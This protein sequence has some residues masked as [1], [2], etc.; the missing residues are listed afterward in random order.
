MILEIEPYM[1]MGPIRLG[2]TIE[3]VEAVI[4]TKHKCFTTHDDDPA[5]LAMVAVGDAV[6][7]HCKRPG[8]CVQV[9]ASVPF[10][11]TF[12]GQHLLGVPFVRILDWFQKIDPQIEI[13]QGL[14]SRKFGIQVTAPNFKE[15]PGMLSDTAGIFESGLNEWYDR[16]S[17]KTLLA[18]YKEAVDRLGLDHEK[19]RDL[20][21]DLSSQYEVMGQVDE[22]ARWEKIWLAKPS[23]KS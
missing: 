14:V 8:F 16:E 23:K 9:S 12:R 6:T 2:M 22:A 4:G 10:Q 20:A 1:S 3:E 11:V 13:N 19:T 7:L 5:G 18:R 15:E 21:L 17:E